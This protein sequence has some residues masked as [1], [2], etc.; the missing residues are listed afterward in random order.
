MSVLINWTGWLA[1]RGPSRRPATRARTVRRRPVLEVLEARNLRS[2]L[3]VTDALDTGLSG[4]GSLRGE[5]A[6][7]A[8]G[9]RI[10]FAGG[11][12]GQT[13]TLNAA[14]GP[15]VLNKD[16]TIQG[17]GAGQLTISGNDATRVFAIAAGATDTIAGLTIARGSADGLS[18]G[19]G[20]ILNNGGATLTLDGCTLS[21]NHADAGSQGGGGIT[22]GG[23]LT[24]NDSTLSGNH[25][26]HATGGVGAAGG[27]MNFGTL[28][29]SGCTLSGNTADDAAQGG[30][31]I[32]NSFAGTATIAHS[33][34]SGNHADGNTLGGGGILNSGGALRLAGSTL[35]GNTAN[36][37]T[38]G[39]GILNSGALT[40]DQSTVSDGIRNVGKGTVTFVAPPN[41]DPAMP[42][43]PEP[44]A[45][46]VVA[47]LVAV[48]RKRKRLWVVERFA[49]TGEVKAEFVSPFQ[50]PRFHHIAVMVV[51]GG[52]AGM[53]PMAGMGGHILVT[54][55]R[56]GK[57]HCVPFPI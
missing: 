11:L 47:S 52:M 10:V 37:G 32:F 50:R 29:V 18:F 15:L 41:P 17:P 44:A 21:G 9:D 55:V 13:I 6:A 28:T 42:P 36:G 51:E 54:A 33:T 2:T 27:I 7:A 30:G 56:N 5:I 16:L 38:G 31:G 53:D 14:K 40:L 35:S 57:M 45:R 49:D 4:D 12:A 46:P 22:N 20:G 25:A 24:V 23:T 26:D 34:L 39:G 43:M 8:A 1:R 48:G 19:G 3:T